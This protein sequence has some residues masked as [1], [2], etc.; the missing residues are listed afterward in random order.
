MHIAVLVKT[1]VIPMSYNWDT[2][3]RMSMAESVIS[4][5]DL[6]VLYRVILGYGTQFCCWSG[7]EEFLQYG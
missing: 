7:V 3:Q 4:T 1:Y 6:I 2:S 5:Y